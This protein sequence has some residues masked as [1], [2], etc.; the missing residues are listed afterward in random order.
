MKRIIICLTIVL[1]I[2]CEDNAVKTISN[3]KFTQGNYYGNYIYTLNDKADTGQVEITFEDTL[4]QCKPISGKSI[5]LGKGTYFVQDDTMKITDI[6][7]RVAILDWTQVMDGK[8]SFSVKDKTLVLEQK[9]ELTKT[10]KR[11]E[12]TRTN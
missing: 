4:Y 3:D 8:F 11:F 5:L 6:L 10:K 2:G 7:V 9:N 1:I 12:L